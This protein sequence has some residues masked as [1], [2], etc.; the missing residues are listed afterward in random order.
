MRH[1][2]GRHHRDC[3]RFRRHASASRGS[4]SLRVLESY[5]LGSNL[6]LLSVVVPAGCEIKCGAFEHR[7]ALQKVTIDHAGQIGVRASAAAPS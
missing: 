5:S 4:A 1:C 2:P 7:T 6:C 3:E